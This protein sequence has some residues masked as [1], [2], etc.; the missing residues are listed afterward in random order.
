MASEVS[1]KLSGWRRRSYP[2]EIYADDR[3]L[4]KTETPKS[5]GYVHIPLPRHSPAGSYTVMLAG[6]ASLNDAF[7]HISELEAA[8]NTDSS[9][10]APE[11]KNTLGIVEIEFLTETAEN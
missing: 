1:M 3:L 9:T 2:I 6:S 5:L 4:V 11:G 8:N 7:G 10:A